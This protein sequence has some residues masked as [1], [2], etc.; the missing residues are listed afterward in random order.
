VEGINGIA[1]TFPYKM[2]DSYSDVYKQLETVNLKEET[3]F[4]NVFFSIMAYSNTKDMS[5]LE[6]MFMKDYTKEEWYV[7]GF[8]NYVT[9]VPMIEIPI[10]E[11]SGGYSLELDDKLWDTIADAKQIYYQK[12]GRGFKYLGQDYVGAKDEK[13]HPMVTA[14]GSWP[15]INGTTIFYQATDSRVTEKGTVYSGYTKAKLNGQKEIL[16]Y[17][18]WDPVQEGETPA[19]GRIIGYDEADNENAFMEKGRSQLEPGVTLDFIFDY[20]DEQGQLISTEKDGSLI[21]VSTDNLRVT[22]K[23][24]GSC[25]LKHGVILTDVYQRTFESEMVETK[26][27]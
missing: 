21:V 20:Y 14:D 4:S 27:N 3:D 17:I 1:L 2:W 9:T 12:T 15:A 13:G 19:S 26:V 10:H 6:A 8:E 23:S 5:E 18:E 25:E 11:T 16:V 7:K 24:L 22:D